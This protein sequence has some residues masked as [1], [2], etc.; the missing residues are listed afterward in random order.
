MRARFDLE[1]YPTR[2]PS[3]PRPSTGMEHVA[4]AQLAAQ[5][6]APLACIDAPLPLQ[7]RWVAGMLADFD[8]RRRAA[9]PGQ[10]PLPYEL[11]RDAHM[12]QARLP[13]GF[14][15]W[16]ARLAA[17]FAGLG[18]PALLAF[19]LGR[20]AAAASLGP[21]EL[22][23]VAARLRRLQALKWQHFARRE[24]H[25]AWRLRELAEGLGAAAGGGASSSPSAAASQQGQADGGS[26]GGAG[27]G[28]AG[29]GGE[30]GAGPKTIVALVGRQHAAALRALWEDRGS[31]LWRDAMP[32]EFS[33][34]RVEEVSLREAANNV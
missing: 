17:A 19:K 14:A 30:A 25:M 2:R 5:A 16:D 10:Q 32:R 34:S 13:P 23:A 12:L 15:E 27:G 20:A 28:G 31:A 1:T 11:L 3:P 9:A 7:E 21:G 18:S 8:G 22:P 6:G 4:A 33:P 26:I 24:L 29:G